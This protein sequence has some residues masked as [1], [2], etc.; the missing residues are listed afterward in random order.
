MDCPSP[1]GLSLFFP[2]STTPGGVAGG[3]AT[4]VSHPQGR[5]L[6][7]GGGGGFRVEMSDIMTR[8]MIGKLEMPFI[9]TE[10]C[11][12]TGRVPK[13]STLSR[14]RPVLLLLLPSHHC[15]ASR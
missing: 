8:F 14:L 1:A 12:T 10:N 15:L 6:G 11:F 5:S 4:K 2:N 7:A 9:G 3:N 13:L